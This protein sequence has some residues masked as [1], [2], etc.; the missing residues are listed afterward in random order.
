MNLRD[1]YK[2]LMIIRTPRTDTHT[3]GNLGF[4][5]A[6][7]MGISLVETPYFTMCN[8]D[9]E[10]INRKWWWGCMDTFDKVADATP[11]RPAVM[12][13]P[14]S[15]K[16]PDWSVGRP[17]GDD[18]YILPYKKK[19]SEE[20]W[21]HLV[22][23]EH[24]VN[25]YLTIMPGTLIDGVT[26]YCSVVRTDRFLKIGILD[27]RF[28]P[29]GGEDYDYN[30]RAN[31]TGFR[32][33]GTTMSWVF[34]HWSKSFATIQEQQATKDLIDDKLRWNN[35]NEKWGENFDIWGAKDSGKDSLPE[36]TYIPL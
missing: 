32:S 2:N 10:F 16:L 36:I 33:V 19:Y 27:E 17:K 20:D 15:I 9:V 11:D 14:A 23:D 13:N 28:Y 3:K 1:K 26:M 24:Y 22:N 29:G 25:E 21:Q 34:H 30:C 31:L 4:A 12:V 35:N 7:N 6:T 5:K 18:F 8:D